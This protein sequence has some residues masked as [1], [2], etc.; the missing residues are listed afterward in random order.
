MERTKNWILNKI[1]LFLDP[2]NRVVE[3]SCAV[4][5]NFLMTDSITWWGRRDGLS[6]NPL[7]KMY[8]ALKC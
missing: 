5:R 1:K 7:F 4:L 2:N 6:T 3:L 8:I